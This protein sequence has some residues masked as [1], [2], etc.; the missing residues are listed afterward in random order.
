MSTHVNRKLVGGLGDGQ[1]V[2]TL[3]DLEHYEY[4]DYRT[5][6]LFNRRVSAVSEVEQLERSS[7]RRERICFPEGPPLY[8]FVEESLSTRL[9]IEML[10]KNHRPIKEGG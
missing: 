6:P 4:Q 3:V 1:E 2:Q 8:F 10:I 9:A 5:S 7:Y